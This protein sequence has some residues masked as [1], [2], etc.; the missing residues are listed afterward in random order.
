[1]LRPGGALHFVEHGR[2]PDVKV[3]R[4]QDRLTPLQRR[5][6]GGCHLNRPIDE[7]IAGAGLA[8]ERLETFHLRGPKIFG[9][10]FEGVAVKP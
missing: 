1:V 7:L 5:L 4:G 9:F 3:A 2:S 8:H 6:C 10:T